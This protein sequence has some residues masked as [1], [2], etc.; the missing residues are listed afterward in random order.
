[1][2]FIYYSSSES[3]ER[4]D[5]KDVVIFRGFFDETKKGPLNILV[6]VEP[7]ELGFYNIE[8]IKKDAH[9]FDIILV[10]QEELLKLPNSKLFLPLIGDCWVHGPVKNIE[11][12]IS[13][14]CGN[15]KMLKGHLLRR[16]IWKNQKKITA[17]KKFFLSQF[18]DEGDN[19]DNNYIM[20][21][22]QPKGIVF[23]KSMFH[24]AIENI[25][26][27]NWITEKIIDCFRTKVVPIYYG[28]PNIAEYYDIR[29]IIMIDSV[30]EAIN[31]CN[32]LTEEDYYSRLEY[33]EKNYSI[34]IKQK[35]STERLVEEANSFFYPK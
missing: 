8:K 25:K 2:G 6:I 28:C 23:E 11:F 30:E 17:P 10:W 14:I 26:L 12:A 3:F 29:G 22:N 34:S 4:Q 18:H 33:V 20:E 31:V 27:D 15:K 35:N 1:M 19:V 13:M 16:E 24:I 32:N 5:L 21:K 7:L 9:H